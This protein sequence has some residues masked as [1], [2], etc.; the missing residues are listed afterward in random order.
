MLC[1]IITTRAV[2]RKTHRVPDILVYAHNWT[3]NRVGVYPGKLSTVARLTSLTAHTRAIISLRVT[4]RV[5]GETR[6]IFIHSRPVSLLRFSRAHAISQGDYKVDRRFI[7]CAW[8]WLRK[9]RATL[10]FRNGNPASRPLTLA[11]VVVEHACWLIETPTIPNPA[12]N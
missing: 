5:S 12:C 2:A 4:P 9:R 7:D 6:W 1:C 10:R 8:A 11:N 3:V